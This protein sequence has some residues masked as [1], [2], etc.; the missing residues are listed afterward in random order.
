MA[1]IQRWRSR[2]DVSAARWVTQTW[3]SSARLWTSRR[4]QRSARKPSTCRLPSRWHR[5]SSQRPSSSGD[6]VGQKSHRNSNDCGCGWPLT[7]RL[8]SSATGPDRPKWVNKKE[9]RAAARVPGGAGVFLRGP[10]AGVASGVAS[11]SHTWTATSGS[12]KPL[13]GL[14]HSASVRIGVKAGRG[15]TIW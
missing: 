7:A 8:T 10:G 3:T 2:L 1:S 4:G 14:T 11:D 5:W 6:S 13:S 15:V 12:V 9:P